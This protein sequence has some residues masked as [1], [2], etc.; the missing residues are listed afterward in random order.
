ML[1]DVLLAEA[2]GVLA[3]GELM[4]NLVLKHDDILEN[5]LW[6]A[7]HYIQKILSG[8]RQIPFSKHY[9]QQQDCTVHYIENIIRQLLLWNYFNWTQQNTQ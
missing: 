9:I 6:L 5:I 1:T 8:R 7:H 3:S 2:H 4:K